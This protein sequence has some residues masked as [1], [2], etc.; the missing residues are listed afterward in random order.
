MQLEP[1]GPDPNIQFCLAV[2]KVAR[3]AG[4]TIEKL[5]GCR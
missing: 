5:H 3:L 2:E 1:F 4:M